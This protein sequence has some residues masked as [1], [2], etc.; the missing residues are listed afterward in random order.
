MRLV[1]NTDGGSRGNPGLAAY[2]FLVR[3]ERGEVL[4]EDGKFL[5]LATNNEAEYTGLL[6]VLQWLLTWER[7]IEVTN[8]TFYL[9]SNLVVE[10]VTGHWK[11]KEARLQ[12]FVTQIREKL[13]QINKPYVIQYVPRAQNA[14]A[15]AIVNQKLDAAQG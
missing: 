3:D 14:E 5:G 10:Q 6:A 12:K 13:Q 7:L 2:G 11:I 1:I 8:L 4:Q 15:D 9:D